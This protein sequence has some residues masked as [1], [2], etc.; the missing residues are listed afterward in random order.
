[1]NPAEADPWVNP[2]DAQNELALFRNRSEKVT[3]IVPARNEE[4]GIA[5]VIT[6]GRPYCDELLVVDGHSTDRTRAIAEELGARVVLDNRKG[7][8]E[9]VRLGIEEATGDILVFI[10]AD[11]AHRPADIPRLVA[12]ILE[13]RADHV[14]GSRPKGG[15]DEL[16]GDLEKFARM[17]GSDIITLGINYR[18]DVRLSDSQ[19]GFRAI[20]A[21][22]ARQLDLREDITT[23]EQE[24]TIKTLRKGFRMAEVPAHEYARRYGESKIK[25][26]RVSFRYVYSWLRYMFF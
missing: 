13:G 26:T 15:S 17:I 24:M 1:M 19:N 20:R 8:G 16:H 9:A 12:P 3:L 14:V 11:H 25:L 10:D 6:Y 2:Y 22:V 21:A 23:I 18:F 5:D 4:G 7:K